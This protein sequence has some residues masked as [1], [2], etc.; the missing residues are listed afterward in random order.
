MIKNLS[1]EQKS[2]LIALA[3]INFFNYVD[4]Q[5]I[6]PLFDLIKQ[7]FLVSDFQLG[8]LGTVFMFIHSL[9]SLPFG[10]WADKYSRKTIIAGGVLFWSVAS[11][12]SGLAGSFKSLLGIRS[13]VGVGEAAY[14]PAATAMITD[15]VPEN[16]RAQ[17]QGI[18]NAGLFM[19]GTLG[20]MIGGV[21][22]FYFHSWRVAFFLVS[23]P[24]LAL[25]WW[26]LRLKD[27]RAQSPGH[28]LNFRSL[29]KNII[30]IWILLGGILSTFATGAFVS[31]GIEFVIRYK[32]YNLRD[33]SLVLG[34]TLM[35]AGV[36]GVFLGSL[37]ADFLH[38]KYHF[39][40][41]IVVAASQVIAAPVLYW[42]ISS[43]GKSPVF[44]LSFFIGTM[45]LA[46][47]YGPV[48]AV[49]HD[50]VPESLRATSFALYILVIH[51]LGDTLAPAIIGKISD[52]YSLRIG[53]ELATIF[54]FLSGLCFF[55]VTEII[56]KNKIDM[57]QGAYVVEID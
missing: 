48:T 1:R 45:L 52:R 43:P 10:V 6:F 53:L 34:G 28:N 17:A 4:R 55:I 12:A 56:R 25:A 40:R 7:E 44:F 3:L 23:V 13:L 30:Y 42:G 54:V 51:L 33:A 16:F 18:F 35:L 39:G 32:G 14:A 37:I 26:S 19:G 57:A 24:G 5:V 47:Y 29:L 31:W 38:E 50:V 9:A 2:I 21:I 27:V 8:L 20:A 22:A 41:S 15:N 46:F 36:V 11:F 49:M